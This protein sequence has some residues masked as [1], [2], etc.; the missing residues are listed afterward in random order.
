[1]GEEILS[2][3]ELDALMDGVKSGEVATDEGT[4]RF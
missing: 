3:D 1:M 4:A 2:R